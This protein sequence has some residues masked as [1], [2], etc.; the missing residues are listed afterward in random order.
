MYHD[1]NAHL[2][3]ED[4]DDALRMASHLVRELA[5]LDVGSQIPT[6]RLRD[7]ARYAERIG[8]WARKE[9]KARGA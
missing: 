3:C 6:S 8:R 9:L 2:R 1:A 4:E 7:L 5:D